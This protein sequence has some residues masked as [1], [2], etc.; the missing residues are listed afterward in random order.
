MSGPT[1]ST[2]DVYK[3]PGNWKSFMFEEIFENINADNQFSTTTWKHLLINKQ[4]N[5]SLIMESFIYVKDIDDWIFS[6]NISKIK[7]MNIVS[8]I[9]PITFEDILFKHLRNSNL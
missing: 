4:F 3:L 5:A 9:P 6:T 8:N 7:Q 2:D 1:V